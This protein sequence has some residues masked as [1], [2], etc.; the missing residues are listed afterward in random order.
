MKKIHGQN[1]VSNCKPMIIIQNSYSLTEINQDVL[2]E[3]GLFAS[4]LRG[5]AIYSFCSVGICFFYS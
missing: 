5:T 2:Y 4:F 1:D 3:K